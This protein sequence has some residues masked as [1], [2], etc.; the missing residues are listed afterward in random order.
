MKKL[1]TIILITY[2]LVSCSKAQQPIATVV[3]APAAPLIGGNPV[4]ALPRTVVFKMNGDWSDY[5]PVNVNASG[6]ALISYPDPRD[7]SGASIPLP[8][9]DGWWLDRRGGM[10]P[11]TRF[12]RYTWDE[13]RQLPRVP[14]RQVLIKAIIPSAR[15][16]ETRTLDIPVGEATVAKCNELLKNETITVTV[17]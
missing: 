17:P 5:V 12:T 3:E 1:I 15:V 9:D 13:Y 11:N 4:D 8:L 10:G 2:C 14:N 7:I 16:T 6:T